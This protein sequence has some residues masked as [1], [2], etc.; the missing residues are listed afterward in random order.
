MGKKDFEHKDAVDFNHQDP[1][2]DSQMIQNSFAGR[3]NEAVCGDHLTMT[4]V[5]SCVV[6][7]TVRWNV[8]MTLLQ[9]AFIG[10]KLTY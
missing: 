1:V 3:A 6:T 4:E 9:T 7:F 5:D 2:T 10:R 8:S